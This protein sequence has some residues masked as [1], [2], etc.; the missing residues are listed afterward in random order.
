[1]TDHGTQFTSLPRETCSDPGAN[2]FQRFLDEKG[3]KHVKARVRHPQ[4]NG[5]VERLYQ[6][7]CGLRNHLGSWDKAAEYYNFCMPHMSLENGRLRTP[8]YEA[9]MDKMRKN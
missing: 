2:E 5:K 7:L 6:T 4:S 9:F 1:M 3:I 8:P